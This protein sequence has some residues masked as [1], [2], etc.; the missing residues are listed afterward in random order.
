MSDVDTPAYTGPDRRRRRP[1]RLIESILREPVAAAGLA[2]VLAL[3]AWAILASNAR[4]QKVARDSK[5]TADFVRRC[6]LDPPPRA[7][8]PVQLGPSSTTTTRP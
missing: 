7:R 8:C 3:F 1:P 5:V 6:I 4:S 2:V